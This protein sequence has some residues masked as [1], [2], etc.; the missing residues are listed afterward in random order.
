MKGRKP[1]IYLT[2]IILVGLQAITPA[3]AFACSPAWYEPEEAIAEADVAFIGTLAELKE[4]K[5]FEPNGIDYTAHYTYVFQVLT[6]W[7][8]VFEP[9][10][11]SQWQTHVD[12]PDP[13]EPPQILPC[14]PFGYELGFTYLVYANYDSNNSLTATVYYGRND[15]P[16]H[17]ISDV[18]EEFKAF[19]AGKQWTQPVGMPIAGSDPSNV[20][21]AIFLSLLVL[22]LGLFLTRL[23]SGIEAQ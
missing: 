14:G 7:K 21:V 1:V 5:Q 22:G 2:A 23:K 11:T 16:V 12:V 4:E 19:G 3:V 17:N 18:A 13:G 9:Q 8:G 10:V 20:D 6:S 15:G